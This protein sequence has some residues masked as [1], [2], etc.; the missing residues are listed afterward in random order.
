MRTARA[1]K[2]L[3]RGPTGG[4]TGGTDRGPPRWL[5]WD[6]AQANLFILHDTRVLPDRD[7]REVVKRVRR[8]APEIHASVVTETRGRALAQWSQLLR[9]TL[10]V[11]LYPV[12]GLRHWRGR[13]AKPRTRGKM[14]AYRVLEA[15]GVPV[16][17]WREIVPGLALDP[18]EWGPWTVVKPDLG[19][20]GIDVEAVATAA[21]RYRAAAELPAGHL[22]LEGPLLAQRFIPTVDGPAFYRVMTCFGEPLHALHY[23]T[24]AAPSVLAGQPPEVQPSSTSGR[25]LTDEPDVLALARRVHALL[26]DVPMIGCDILREQGTG[27]LWIAE[28]NQASV[29][30]FCSPVG[31]ATQAK[32]GLDF[33]GQFGALDR[34]AE[35]MVQATRLLARS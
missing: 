6:M 11:E 13:V 12:A 27:Q 5:Q 28:I 31:I 24:E 35:A 10:F 8:L 25:R 34:A 17:P 26:P 2:T 19:R 32:R 7:F 18:A 4:P 30:S 22:G 1:A 29:W 14:A 16:P 9:P 33:Y 21:V 3:P 15:G 20:R 23:F